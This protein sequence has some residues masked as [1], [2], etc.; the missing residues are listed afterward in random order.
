MHAITATLLFK[1]NP[2]KPITSESATGGAYSRAM[3]A[4]STSCTVV[5]APDIQD[6]ITKEWRLSLLLT[7]N[8]A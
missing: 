5:L 1:A 6:D 4:A 8:R 3:N 7:I 2:P